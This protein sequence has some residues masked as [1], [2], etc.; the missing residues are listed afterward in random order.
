[1]SLLGVG[2]RIGALSDGGP[3]NRAEEREAAAAVRRAVDLGVTYFDT[4]P[5]YGNGKS[6]G[7]LGIAL[8]ELSPDERKRLVLSTKVGSHLDR[9]NQYDADTIKWSFE[10]SLMKISV[11]FIHIVYV[12]DPTE[13][14]HM[15]LILSD[16]GALSAL[17]EFKSQGV[18]G[19]IGMGVGN[20]RFLRRFVDSGRADV[21][22]VPYDFNPVRETGRELI[23]YAEDA[24]VG[25]V[26]A[27]PYMAG[28][29]AAPDVE[30]IREHATFPAATKKRAELI[31]RWCR[32]HGH[33]PATMAMQFALR[34]T[35][36]GT[37][38]AGPRTATEVTEN[39]R[40]ATTEIA[41]EVWDEFM[42]FL[43]SLDPAAPGGEA[44]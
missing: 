16:N 21:I 29:L 25:V 31:Y 33:D 36:I 39:V 37:V 4:A 8:R 13:D 2:G 38:L 18:I 12:H 23:G 9:L 5:C 44:R 10:Q 26:N 41:P 6:E 32:D 35:G 40:H 22:I 1:M 24:G 3:P 27:S 14:S 42:T 11:E 34:H 43:A 19:A 20:H 15:D 28:L 17:E 7:Y 30:S